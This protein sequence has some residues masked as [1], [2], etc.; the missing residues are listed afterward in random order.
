MTIFHSSK[1]GPPDSSR[2]SRD[3]PLTPAIV[4]IPGLVLGALGAWV[5]AAGVRTAILGA[6]SRRWPVARGRIH[7]LAAY[8]NARLEREVNALAECREVD[9]RTHIFMPI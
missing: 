6:W 1:N 3:E 5:F 4:L 2:H 8:A 9:A 7:A